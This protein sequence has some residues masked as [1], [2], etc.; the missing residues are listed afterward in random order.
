MTVGIK[1]IALAIPK[2]YID[3][4]EL[5]RLRDVP[6]EKITKGLGIKKI[7]VCGKDENVVTLGFEAIEELINKNDLKPSQIGRIYVATE[8]SIDESK[9]LGTNIIE[10]LEKEYGRESFANCETLEVK[11]ACI[12]GS[13]ALYDCCNW[14]SMHENDPRYAIVLCDDVARYELKTSPEFTQGAGGVA[15]LVS[16]WDEK[17]TLDFSNVG[18]F[19]SEAYDFYRP[20]G[21]P[22]PKV[23]GNFS[24]YCYLYSMK[25]ALEDFKRK[26]HKSNSFGDSWDFI[27]SLNYLVFHLPYVKIAQYVSSYFL[28]HELRDK[29]IWKIIERSIGEEPDDSRKGI[30]SSFFSEEIWKLSEEYRRKFVKT[31]V[32]KNFYQAKVEPTTYGCSEVGNIYTGSLYLSLISLLSKLSECHGDTYG[33]SLGF[34]SYGSGRGALI[35]KGYLQNDV[36][37]MVRGI[38]LNNK[39]AHREKISI[40]EYE[41]LHNEGVKK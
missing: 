2:H 23:R 13:Y 8:S 32:F 3:T 39:L 35:F 29:P 37:E 19:T 20:F 7:A 18:V 31:E 11:F 22:F 40:E 1:D 28:R 14:V 17:I 15:M 21:T 33:N 34:C 36:D 25:K 5:A 16:Q 4:A 9:P 12:A 30:E 26:T 38:N 6:E 41:I 27:S 24:N 10:E